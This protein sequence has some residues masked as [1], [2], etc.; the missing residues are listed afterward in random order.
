VTKIAPQEV[1]YLE[2]VQ[3]ESCCVTQDCNKEPNRERQALKK[4]MKKKEEEDTEWQKLSTFQGR[5][6]KE[7]YTHTL[8]ARRVWRL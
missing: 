6:Q 8:K 1:L 3:R 2:I 7:E 4:V 5:L